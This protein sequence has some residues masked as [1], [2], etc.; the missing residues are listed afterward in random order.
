MRKIA[1]S[2]V[3]V[4]F[5]SASAFAGTVGFTPSVVG[6]LPGDP[7]V[8]EISVEAADTQGFN[9]VSILMGSMENLP[10]SFT[11]DQGFSDAATSTPPSP[12]SFGVYAAAGGGDLFVGGN[13]DD[14]DGWNATLVVGTLTVDTTGLRADPSYNIVVDPA[15]EDTYAGT[16]LSNVQGTE[17]LSGMGTIRIVPEPA[18]LALLGIGGLVALRRRRTA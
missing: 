11:Y 8:F 4:A 6:V 5:A 7:A 18:T 9:N 15:F 17:P 12:M 2:L 16:N 10:M 3:V 13:K 14:D 1:V